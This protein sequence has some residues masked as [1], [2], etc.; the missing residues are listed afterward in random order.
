M[1]PEELAAVGLPTDIIAML[2]RAPRLRI[3]GSVEELFDRATGDERAALHQVTYPLPDGREFVEATV[4][5][6]RNGIAVNYTEPHMRRR[7][8]DCMVIGDDRPTDKP[9]FRERFGYECMGDRRRTGHRARLGA[10]AGLR[11]LDGRR[12]CTHEGR[13]YKLV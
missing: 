9:R 5:R 4:A 1:I 3:A 8:P 12:Q 13:S 6:V 2:E 7:D 11:R 10:N